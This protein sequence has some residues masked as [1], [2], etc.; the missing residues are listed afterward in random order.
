MLKKGIKKLRPWYHYDEGPEIDY[1]DEAVNRIFE[2][3]EFRAQIHWSLYSDEIVIK[4]AEDRITECKR[5][6]ALI[7]KNINTL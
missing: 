5:L 4:L 7:D 1:D 6:Q 3:E 2:S